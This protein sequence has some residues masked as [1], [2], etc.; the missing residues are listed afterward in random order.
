[1]ASAFDGVTVLDLTQGMAG[2][3]ASTFLCDNGARVLRAGATDGEPGYR[4]L[5]RGCEQVDLDLGDK[6][7]FHGLVKR[8]DVLLESFAPSSPSQALVDYQTLSAINRRLVQCSITAYG[9]KGP[10][11]DEPPIDELVMA[12]LGILADQPSFRPGPVHVIHPL[13][14]V[15]AGLLA[16]TGIVAALYQREKTGLGVK[17]ETSLMAGMLVF[18]PRIAGEKLSPASHA[19]RT[20]TQPAGGGPFYSLHQCADGEWIHVACIHGGFVKKAAAAMGISSVLDD[21]KFNDG[22]NM[23]SE[24]VRSELFGIV[25]AAIG[26]KS[27]KAW[28]SIFE[29][30]D[31]PYGRACT[32]EE[33]MDNPQVHANGMVVEIEHPQLGLMSQMGLPIALSETPGR[34]RAV[35]DRDSVPL[36]PDPSGLEDAESG[37]QRPVDPISPL[38]PPLSGVRVLEITNVIAG[39]TAGKLL[40]DLGADVIKLEPLNGEISR[41]IARDYFYYLNSNKRGLSVDTRAPQGREAVQRLAA[42]VDVVLANTR[43]GATER[44]GVDRE[45]L[46]AA[47]PGLITAHVTAFGPTG[48]YSHRAGL[49]PLSQALMGLGRAQGGAENPPV[50]LGRL[51]VTDFAAG[52]MAT[53][54]A[55][56]ALFVR[57]RTGVSQ[58]VDTCLLNSG[59]VVSAEEFT[60]YE[61]KPPRRLADKGQYGLGALH[62]LYETKDGW[63]YLIADAGVA[64]AQDKWSSL[65]EAVDRPDLA[66]DVRFATATVR[67]TNDASLA[68]ELETTFAGGTVDHWSERLSASGVPHAPVR[69]PAVHWFFSDPH[70]LANDMVVESHQPNIG[71]M[72]VSGHGLVFR[73]SKEIDVLPTPLLGEH[74]TEVLESLG[75]SSDQIDELYRDGV[76]KTEEPQST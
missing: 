17:V 1:M 69:E 28:E 45:S 22:R 59:I 31:V 37:S 29:E 46:K 68:G 8:A 73:G 65:C 15:G 33:A 66:G 43:P 14:S 49:D 74:T 39:P 3:L 16:A 60:R 42:S 35:A 61:G 24:E 36:P 13:P 40:A 48:P 27:C 4:V 64:D 11:R 30:A 52:A 58:R 26:T 50:Y 70:V 9:M 7:A 47:N 18:A 21:P 67:D 41:E 56:I 23:P 71:L 25:A 10:L 44:M 32:T 20:S 12:R 62:R 63:L 2:A 76:V 5:T 34:A 54:G 51:A 53:L 75:Y 19:I 55:V 57:E 38:P 6:E 72:K